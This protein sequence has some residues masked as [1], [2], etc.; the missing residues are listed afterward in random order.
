MNDSNPD[1]GEFEIDLQHCI[2]KECKGDLVELE[3]FAQFNWVTA[4]Y[5]CTSCGRDFTIKIET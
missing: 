3:S 1:L 4:A 5:R 2:W